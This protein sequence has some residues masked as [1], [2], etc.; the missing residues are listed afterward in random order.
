[1]I[2]AAASAANAA[3]ERLAFMKCRVRCARC[4]L[5]LHRPFCQESHCPEQYAT[6]DTHRIQTW[7]PIKKCRNAILNENTFD[8]SHYFVI[9][10][11]LAP[12][13]PGGTHTG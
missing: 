5:S 13:R 10:G 3:I 9:L 6:H 4:G 11:A 8:D 1:M 2:K 12:W 7:Q